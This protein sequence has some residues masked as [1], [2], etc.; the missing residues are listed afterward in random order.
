M[1]IGHAAVALGA[2]RAEPRVNVGLL[3]FAAFLADFL[4]GIFAAF[5][6][7][8]AHVPAD[9]ASRHY[10]TFTFPYSHGLVSLLLWGILLG[11]L[12]CWL[13][14]RDRTRAFLVVAALVFS[15]FILD[16]LVHVPELPV[17]GENSPKVGLALWNHMPLELTLETLMAI[18]GIAIYWR[19]A[20]GSGITRWAM[21]IFALLLTA[22]TWT[23]LFATQAP[24]P[25]QLVP[26][27]II[28]PLV[29]SVIP[30]AIDWK[31]TAAAQNA[32]AV[33]QKA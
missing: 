30:F 28:A 31:R 18:G 9:F 29:F 13:D 6:L 25:S 23:Q 20:G 12:L 11:A 2:S 1:G 5:G 17:L 27:W 3:I 33:P 22:L 10:L 16:A 4:L 7:E 24:S 21:A 32:A 14:R 26:T 15:H 8:Q 19:L